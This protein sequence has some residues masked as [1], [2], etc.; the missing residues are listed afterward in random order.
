MN[1]SLRWSCFSVLS[2]DEKEGNR[3]FRLE[4]LSHRTAEIQTSM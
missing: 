3:Q 2:R 4:H 1:R